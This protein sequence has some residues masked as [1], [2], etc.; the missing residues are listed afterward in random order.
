MLAG[1]VTVGVQRHN[2]F[3][4]FTDGA[5]ADFDDYESVSGRLIFR[6]TERFAADVKYSFIDKDG[7]TFLYH[8]ATDIKDHDGLLL[9]TSPFTAD[10]GE[11]AGLRQNGKVRQ[12]SAVLRLTYAV[13]DFDIVSISSYDDFENSATYDVD[14]GPADLFSVVT[15]T[16]D[17]IL[18][19]EVR[20]QST[21]D[22][23]FSWLVGGFYT[24]LIKTD[25]NRCGNVLGGIFVGGT[26]IFQ[27]FP[28]SD[29]RAYSYFTDLEY[30][31]GD[32]WVI[33]GGVRYDNIKR[34]IDVAGIGVLAV[35]RV[36]KLCQTDGRKQA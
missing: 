29:L 11:L 3:R 31:L 4:D 27:A 10:S 23:P 21:G 25:C 12:K 36:V 13:D 22:G 35:V 6:P 24:D 1:R 8:Q 19:Q 26:S 30:A 2:G 34:S 7:G 17:D 20:L 15:Y 14:S 28:N 33:G 32:N 18:S 9:V 5:D 16:E